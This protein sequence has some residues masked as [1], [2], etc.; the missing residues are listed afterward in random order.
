MLSNDRNQVMEERIVDKNALPHAIDNLVRLVSAKNLVET[1]MRLQRYGDVL[2]TKLARFEIRQRIRMKKKVFRA[3]EIL[4]SLKRRGRHNEVK[5]HQFRREGT[6][7]MLR[8]LYRSWRKAVAQQKDWV[9][10]AEYEIHCTR[11]EEAVFKALKEHKKTNI[12]LSKVNKRV[13]YT[14]MAKLKGLSDHTHWRIQNF[15]HF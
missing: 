3:G 9:Y 8:L 4:R 6:R 12:V 1:F 2:N 15:R 14:V 7:N 5:A 11:L 13:I 10:R